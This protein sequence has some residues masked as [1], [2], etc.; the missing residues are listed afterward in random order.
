MSKVT[1]PCTSALPS[2]SL[3]ARRQCTPRD[4]LTLPNLP[5]TN[6]KHPQWGC[7]MPRKQQC[8]GSERRCHAP[9]ST[10]PLA[11]EPIQHNRAAPDGT[12]AHCHATSCCACDIASTLCFSG[13]CWHPHGWREAYMMALSHCRNRGCSSHSQ[14]G[15]CGGGWCAQQ[16]RERHGGHKRGSHAPH[17]HT[18]VLCG[19]WLP[20]RSVHRC[21]LAGMVS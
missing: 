1:S 19:P 5:D 9:S 6:T 12:C 18:L 8:R 14:V 10:I 2:Y 11:A 3:H 17:G 7:C 4:R 20:T 13:I 21:R 15:C 16:A